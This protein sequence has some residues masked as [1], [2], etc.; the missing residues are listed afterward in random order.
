MEKREKNNI[1]CTREK[2]RIVF[3]G[4]GADNK[5]PQ[6]FSHKSIVGGVR[7]IKDISPPPI[8]QVPKQAR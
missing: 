7:N 2:L 5:T 4:P 3:H 1:I 8:L 6:N